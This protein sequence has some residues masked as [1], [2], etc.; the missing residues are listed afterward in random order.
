MVKTVAG[1][2]HRFGTRH[3]LYLRKDLVEDTSF[4]FRIGEELTITIVGEKL[5]VEKASHSSAREQTKNQ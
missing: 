1:R 3:T 5:I 4:P 2:I